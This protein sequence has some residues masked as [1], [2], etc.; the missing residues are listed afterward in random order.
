VENFMTYVKD[1]A[2]NGLVSRLVG[3]GYR[4]DNR[5]KHLL[6]VAPDGAD[7]ITLPHGTH[8]PHWAVASL[9]S[10]IRRAERRAG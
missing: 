1:G 9:R 7:R 10:R 8:T 6:L 3:L 5:K 2:V 4:P